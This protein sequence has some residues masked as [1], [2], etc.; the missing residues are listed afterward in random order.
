MQIRPVNLGALSRH[1]RL[2]CVPPGL[3]PKA[4]PYYPARTPALAD[5]FPPALPTA[6]TT[7][8]PPRHRPTTSIHG[9]RPP[10]TSRLSTARENNPAQT[11]APEPGPS[12][13]RVDRLI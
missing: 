4:R 11:G 12:E 1:L 3:T 6:A 7:T 8:G 5:T 13:L 9:P 2:A 10:V